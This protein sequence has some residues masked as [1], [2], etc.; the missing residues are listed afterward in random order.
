MMTFYESNI[1]NNS[2][3]GKKFDELKPLLSKYN[4]LN[5][6]AYAALLQK[7][8]LEGLLQRNFL[9]LPVQFNDNKYIIQNDIAAYSLDKFEAQVGGV[10]SLWLGVTIMLIFEVFE[11]IINLIYMCCLV[12][13]NQ[14]SSATETVD[15][16]F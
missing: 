2:L 13:R 3:F 6:S 10:L 16:G 7:L 1:R 14:R 4:Q 12:K 11:F 9:Q 15:T 8:N 5:R